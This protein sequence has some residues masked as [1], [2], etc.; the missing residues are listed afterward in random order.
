MPQLKKYFT[1]AEYAQLTGIHKN[2]VYRKIEAGQLPVAPHGKPYRIP[3]SALYPDA[4]ESA[5]S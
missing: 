4:K 2:T 1:P 3:A 5:A